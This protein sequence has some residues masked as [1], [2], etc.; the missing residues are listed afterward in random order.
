[1]VKQ[2]RLRQAGGSVSATLPKEMV[3]RMNLGAGDEVFAV[4]TPDGILITPYDDA[5][6]RALEAARRGARRYRNALRRL[7]D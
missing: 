3:D 6:A 7:A 1:M 2:I 4:D 5:T